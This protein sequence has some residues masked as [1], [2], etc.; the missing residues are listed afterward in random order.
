MQRARRLQS[1]AFWRLMGRAGCALK[2]LAV[3]AAHGV[4]ARHA[5]RAIDDLTA[6]DARSLRDL[7]LNRSNAP[8]AADYGREALPPPANTNIGA[9]K[10]DSAA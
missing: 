9:V 6:M 3:R 1:E 8:D 10:T 5:R 4:R 2:R 7:G